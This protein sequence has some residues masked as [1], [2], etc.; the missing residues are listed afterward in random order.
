[1]A[2]VT[3]YDMYQGF[4]KGIGKKRSSAVW[5]AD[6]NVLINEAYKE[7]LRTKVN[8][9]DI[10]QQ[11]ID[12]LQALRFITDSSID[13]FLTTFTR[14]YDP[15]DVAGT[16]FDPISGVVTV[17]TIDTVPNPNR[18]TIVTYQRLIPIVPVAG[19]TFIFPVLPATYPPYYRLQSIQAMLRRDGVDYGYIG[20]KP[21]KSD[22]RSEIMRDPYKKPMLDIDDIERSRIYHLYVQDKL[23]LV[24]PEGVTGKNI[25]IEY[26]KKPLELFLDPNNQSNN[27]DC[28]LGSD[29]QQQIV[30]IAVR[31]FIEQVESRRYQT[32]ITEEQIK[33]RD[34]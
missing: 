8:E 7:W 34:K 27:V 20:S 19:S 11:R 2:L 31:A 29:Q 23:H 33:Q 24:L 32:V 9:S 21:M 26:I 30:D 25:L 4:L 18:T 28:E 15:L 5:P 3:I 6:F 16:V 17:T 10:T 1:M 22:K 14:D 13:V 12:D